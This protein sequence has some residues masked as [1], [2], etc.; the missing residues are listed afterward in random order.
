MYL[1]YGV[2]GFFVVVGD[3]VDVLEEDGNVFVYV[4]FEVYY[5]VYGE[6]VGGVV[7]EFG[8]VVVVCGG[9]EGGEEFFF[10]DCF[11]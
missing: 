3:V 9:E 7:F 6:G 4:F 8:V 5:D 2:E 10:V 1:G 11:C